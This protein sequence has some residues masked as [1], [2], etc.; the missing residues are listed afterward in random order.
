MYNVVGNLNVR[1]FIT[2]L[3]RV[4]DTTAS[5]G[6]TWLPVSFYSTTSALFNDC[7]G[8]IQAIPTDGPPV[9]LPEAF[10]PSRARA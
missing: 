9:V 7:L 10:T 1:D 8:T 2:A 6:M 4:T 5:S 3:Q